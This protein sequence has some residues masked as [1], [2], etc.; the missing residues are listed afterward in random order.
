MN[1]WS[2]FGLAEA[3]RRQ[4]DEAGAEQMMTRFE[5][6]WQFADVSLATSIL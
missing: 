2:M 6:V 1:G 4:G 3:L 5:T